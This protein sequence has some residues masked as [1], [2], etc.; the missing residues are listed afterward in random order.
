MEN[1]EFPILDERGWKVK[2]IREGKFDYWLII[3][4]PQGV[5]VEFELEFPDM[6]MI[7]AIAYYFK[8]DCKPPIRKKSMKLVEGDEKIKNV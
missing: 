5:E 3:R 8:E 1:I 7:E 6:K 2:V 4:C